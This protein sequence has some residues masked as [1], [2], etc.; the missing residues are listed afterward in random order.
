[1]YTKFICI[2]LLIMLTGWA[3]SCEISDL[4]KELLSLETELQKCQHKLTDDS[5]IGQACSRVG[6][7]FTKDKSLKNTVAELLKKLEIPPD[8][9]TSVERDV[10]IRLSPEDLRTLNKFVIFDGDSGDVE[11]ILLKSIVVKETILDKTSDFLSS[12][13]LQTSLHFQANIVILFQVAVLL[14]CV[15]LPLCLGAAKLPVL[16]FMCLYAV[17]TTW[18]KLYYTAAAKKQAVLAKHATVPRA[19]HIERQGWLAAAGD[20]VAGLFS[21][22]ADPC[23]D[24]YTAAMVDPAWEVGLVTALMETVSSCLVIPAQTCGL[25]LGSFYLHILEP[26]PWVWKAPVL[27]LATVVVLFSLLLCCGYEFSIP[28]LLRIGPDRSKKL[29]DRRDDEGRVHINN[30]DSNNGG[31]F[32]TGGWRPSIV[33]RHPSEECDMTD[34]GNTLPYPVKNNEIAKFIDGGT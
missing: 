15:V 33:D 26:L 29:T 34:K 25:A 9:T 18:V 5:Y 22:R 17:F 19:C 13:L 24:Y 3:S 28:F 30:L 8:L 16:L 21:G 14:C 32:V 7:W 4:K 11:E 6:S 2:E 31:N 10:V 27:V 1:M 20:L 12:T 23:E